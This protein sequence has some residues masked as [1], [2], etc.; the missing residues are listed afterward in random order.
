MIKRTTAQKW[1]PSVVTA[2]A[3]TGLASFCHA[4]DTITLSNDASQSPAFYDAG[5]AGA[6]YTWQATGGPNGAGCIKGVIDGATTLEFDPAFNVNFTAGQYY[7]VTVQMMVDPASGVTGT[8]GSGGY[9]NIQLSFRDASY[10]WNGVG[11]HTIFPPAANNWVTYSFPVPGP[12][13][14]VA[15]L[16]L[17]LQAAAAYSGPVTIYIGNVIIKPVPNP[18]VLAAFTNDTVS[19]GWNNY[20]LAASYDP[21]V[22]APY[23]NPV[24]IQRRSVLPRRV[25]FHFQPSNP[26]GLSRRTVSISDSIP[27]NINQ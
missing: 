27:P 24:T 8:S 5:P 13:F 12:S 15:H 2:L 22:D 20:G 11:Y 10:S 3:L 14:T 6:T 4:Q 19:S 9:G 7:Q 21:N 16:Q 18:L 17:Q 25:R 26:Q 23:S 1:I